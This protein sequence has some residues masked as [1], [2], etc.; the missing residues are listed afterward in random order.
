MKTTTLG[1]SGLN[2]SRIAFGTWQLGGE[3]GPVDEDGAVKAIQRARDFGVNF[4]DTAQAYGFGASER[5]LGYALRDELTSARDEL[6]IATKGGLRQTD[7]GVVRDASPEGLRRGVDSSLTALGLD[8]IDLYQVHWPDPAVPFAE[9]AGALGELITEGKIRHVGVSNYTADQIDEF[10][11][12]LPVETVQPPYHLFRRE[13]EDELLPYCAAENIGVLVYGPLAHG[14][15]TGTLTEDTTFDAHDWRGG[16]D[17]FT[18]DAYRLNLAVVRDL[19]MFAADRG[20]TVSQLAIAWTLAQPGVHVAIVG[21][22]RAGHV[23]DS[24]AASEV[25]LTQA[26]LA[27]IDKIMASAAPVAG[28]SPES[29]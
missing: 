18:G 4:F 10:C 11:A 15:L 26:D 19:A 22:R 25:T 29:V 6:V 20:I 16:S 14:L 3:W 9:T 24:L 7:T 12:T 23:E 2:V 1:K 5:M 28:P 17:V 13:I 27:E 8:H 21:A